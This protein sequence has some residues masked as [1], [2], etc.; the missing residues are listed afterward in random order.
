MNLKKTAREQELRKE[1]AYLYE[2]IDTVNENIEHD[3][4][5]L[6]KLQEDIDAKQL[7]RQVHLRGAIEK[8]VAWGKRTTDPGERRLAAEMCHAAF[9]DILTAPQL[10]QLDELDKPCTATDTSAPSDAR[11]T[12]YSWETAEDE[13]HWL[14]QELELRKANAEELRRWCEE[15]LTK[16]KQIKQLEPDPDE[17][18]R[19]IDHA[20]EWMEGQDG[21]RRHAAASLLRY[22]LSA[23]MTEEQRK[24]LNGQSGVKAETTA[25]STHAVT[26]NKTSSKSAT[27]L[28]ALFTNP[29]KA[30]DI[31]ALL[32]KR[33]D[34]QKL[35]KDVVMPV[36]A[37]IDA[38]AIKRFPWAQFRREFGIESDSYKSS[39]NTNITNTTNNPYGGPAFEQTKQE[40]ANILKS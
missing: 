29:D 22:A 37:A 19:A 25:K 10:A 14:K 8:A 24:R 34:G 21:E 35:T 30:D 27:D 2:E 6:D 3:E 32:H 11:R 9:G 39:Y 36:R 28:T 16:L 20:L 38:G 15:L 31:L 26:A 18:R 1:N 23:A 13:N 5:W 33:I 12:L 17:T 7:P 4:E 40:F